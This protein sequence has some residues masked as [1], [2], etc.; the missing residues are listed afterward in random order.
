MPE[1]T[2]RLG[3]AWRANWPQVIRRDALILLAVSLATVFLQYLVRLGV[4]QSAELAAPGFH[5]AVLVQCAFGLGLSFVR[6]AELGGFLTTLTRSCA[7]GLAVLLIAEPTDVTPSLTEAA[8][9]HESLQHLY[10]PALAFAVLGYIRPSFIFLPAWYVITVRYSQVAFTGFSGGTLDIRYLVEMAQYLSLMTVALALARR[11]AALDQS[12]KLDD[13]ALQYCIGFNAIAFHFGNYLWA[14][15]AKIAAGPS[16][17]SWTLENETETVILLALEKGTFLFAQWPAL[18]EAVYQ[19]FAA[20]RPAANAFVVL[21]QL[22]AVVAILRRR[23]MIIASLAYDALHVGLFLLQGLF[24]WP[25]VWINVAV[26]LAVRRLPDQAVPPVARVS[27]VLVMTLL[28]FAGWMQYSWLAWFE[29]NAIRVPFLEVQAP[30]GD[31]ARVPHSFFGTDSY[32]VSHSKID[33]SVQPGHFTQ[34]AWGGLPYDEFKR[35]AGCRNPA[36]L[37]AQRPESDAERA[38]RE[39][40]ATR[41][42]RARHR[43]VLTRVDDEGRYNPYLRFHHHPSNPLLYAGFNQLDLRQV[44]T[45]RLV[46]QSVC[47]RLRNGRLER[48]VFSEYELKIDVAR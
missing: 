38:R 16:V 19:S 30:E 2:A 22:F 3:A 9:R 25:W 40:L 11:W 48:Q 21:T 35:R 37:P 1:A 20:I 36:E 28:G 42:V 23:W 8:W 27:S 45:Y 4:H 33:N 32:G 12:R 24:F 18:T 41:F 26:L 14:G 13:S 7:L 15:I 17:F 29:S 6:Y 10:W 5:A 47:L 43:E 39:D 44:S 31:W 34:A 46:T